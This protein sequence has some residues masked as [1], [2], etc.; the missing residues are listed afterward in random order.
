VYRFARFTL[1]PARLVLEENGARVAL[2][3]KALETLAVLL[4]RAGEVVT[5]AELMDRLWPD[6][7]VEEANLTQ[8]VYLLRRTFGTSGLS[9]AIETLPKCGYRFTLPMRGLDI[10]PKPRR[11]MRAAVAA[12]ALIVAAMLAG[13][14]VTD[15]RA[16][17]GLSAADARSYALGR[18]YWNLRTPAALRRSVLYFRRVAID[19]P[20]NPLGFSGLSDAYLGLYDYDCIGD[21]C[22][23]FEERAKWSAVHAVSVDPASPEAHTSLA[24]VLRVFDRSYAASDRE[25]ARAIALDPRYALAYEWF[26]NSLL[27]RGRIPEAISMLR[28]AAELDPTAPATYGWLARAEY[29]AHRYRDAIAYARDALAIDPSRTETRLVEGLSYEQLGDGSSA[30]AAFESLADAPALVAGVAVRAGNAAG[31]R[32]LIAGSSDHIDVALTFI[33]LGEYPSAVSELRRARLSGDTERTFLALDPRLD[34][35]R[36]DA[37]FAAWTR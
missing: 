5:K 14:F 7:F 8:Y 25:F 17:G 32:A 37:R 29:Y 19:A 16:S 9:G 15:Y 18:Y 2:P 23:V 34:R 20:N 12:A 1:D 22:S 3:R 36:G 13:G 26:G 31:A 33:A 4:E 11:L 28:R 35:V 21:G 6:G 30:I 24:M 27:V 10:V